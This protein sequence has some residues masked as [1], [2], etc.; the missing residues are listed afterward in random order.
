MYD[1]REGCNAII[2]T[3]SNTLIAGCAMTVIPN[4]ITAIAKNAFLGCVGLSSLTIPDGV[5][6]IGEYAFAECTG[7]LFRKVCLS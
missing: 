7:I 2:E 6:S 4:T 3:N 1:S 5:T